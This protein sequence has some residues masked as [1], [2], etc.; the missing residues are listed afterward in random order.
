[1]GFWFVKF[2]RAVWAWEG[3]CIWGRQRTLGGHDTRGGFGLMGS[4]S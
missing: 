3:I 1:M 4:L 2:S